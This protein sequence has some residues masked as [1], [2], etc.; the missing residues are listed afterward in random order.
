MVKA[1]FEVPSSPIPRTTLVEA[2]GR[3][4]LR[5]KPGEDFTP[6]NNIDSP[7]FGSSDLLFVDK[8]RANLMA[9]RL[10]DGDNCEKFIVSSISYYFWLGEFLLISEAFS[11]RKTELE[12]YLF[13]N[14]FSPAV[15]LFMKNLAPDLRL[16]LVKHKAL[17]VEGLHEPVI[18]FERMIFEATPKVPPVKEQEPPEKAP[19][20]EEN[21]A[22]APPQISALEMNEFKRLREFYL[23]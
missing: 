15:S 1:A 6:T 11:R 21:T 22:Q 14:D 20:A 18:H 4:L 7:G 19:P 9:A 17:E 10:L 5:S 3:F 13:L 16:H 2:A 23:S 8:A 12:L